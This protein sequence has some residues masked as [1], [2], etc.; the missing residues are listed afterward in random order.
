MNEI[1][2]NSDDMRDIADALWD[3]VFRMKNEMPLNETREKFVRKLVHIL[4]DQ[5]NETSEDIPEEW[6]A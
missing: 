1:L 4:E 6:Y 5:F 3:V 2:L